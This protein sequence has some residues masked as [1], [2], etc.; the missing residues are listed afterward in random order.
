MKA[1]LE[2]VSACKACASRLLRVL[3]MRSIAE[4]GLQLVVTGQL[5]RGSGS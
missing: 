3:R 5:G 4:H 1:S 2:N